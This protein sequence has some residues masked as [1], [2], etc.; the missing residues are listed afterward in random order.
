MLGLYIAALDTEDERDRLRELYDRYHKLLMKVAFKI[1][2]SPDLAEDAVHETFLA[3]I[4]DKNRIFLQSAVNFRNWS[5]IVVRNK[6]F[7]IL[8]EY[9]NFDDS[10]RL[11]SESG[12]DM[13]DIPSDDAP[14][15]R[16]LIQGDE[17][18]ILMKCLA[19]L[20]PLNRQILEMKYVR[21]MSFAEIC[22]ELN[23]TFPQVNGRLA[24]TREKVKAMLEKE[25]F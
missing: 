11:E 25:A 24:R 21:G 18:A 12:T 10:V 22:S 17:K 13:S 6:C 14:V 15:D 8:R 7:D 5:V 9:K 3:A 16:G 1:V 4:E 23:M 19:E 20:E 2:R